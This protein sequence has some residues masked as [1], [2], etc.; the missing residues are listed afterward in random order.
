MLKRNIFILAAGMLLGG[1]VAVAGEG[2]VTAPSED[3]IMEKTAPPVQST[4][5]SQRA[6]TNPAG[7]AG[8]AVAAGADDQCGKPLPGQ[9]KYLDENQ[10][11]HKPSP[12]DKAAAPSGKS[13]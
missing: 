12:A 6:A 11:V 1:Q 10:P 4:F 13:D 3:Q 9:A 8:D 7:C 5:Q 2:I